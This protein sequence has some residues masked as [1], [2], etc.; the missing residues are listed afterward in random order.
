VDV[1]DEGWA[2]DSSNPKSKPRSLDA[3]PL[4]SV[5]IGGGFAV[6]KRIDEVEVREDGGR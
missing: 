5:F 3:L 1:G 4:V 2:L 6:E